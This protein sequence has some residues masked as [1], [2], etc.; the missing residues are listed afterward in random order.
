[1]EAAMNTPTT[2]TTKPYGRANGGSTINKTASY[3]TCQYE[4][5][6]DVPVYSSGC[7]CTTPTGSPPEHQCAPIG[8]RTQHYTCKLP[9]IIAPGYKRACHLHVLHILRDSLHHFLTRE[10]LPDDKLPKHL[11]ELRNEQTYALMAT[12]DQLQAVINPPAPAKPKAA[13]RKSTAK[14]L[15]DTLNKQS[16][17]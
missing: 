7:A 13:T 1:M 12:Y 10:Q 14:K 2:T 11:V 4:W 8:T 3:M 5:D 6:E 9:A 17:S 16:V 15:A